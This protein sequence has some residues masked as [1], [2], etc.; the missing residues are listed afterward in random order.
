MRHL[1]LPLRFAW[2]FLLLVSLVGPLGCSDEVC[3]EA[4]AKLR[5]CLEQLDCNRVDP[6]DRTRCVASKNEGEDV[7][8]KMSGAPCVAEVSDLAEQINRC[9]PNPVDLCV[10]F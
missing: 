7:L 5:D 10:C 6:A 8:V 4:E 2:T 9:N 3:D 1:H